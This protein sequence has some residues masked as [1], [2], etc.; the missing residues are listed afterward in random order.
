M[1]VVAAH[2]DDDVEAGVVDIA[3]LHAVDA[4]DAAE[5]VIVIAQRL[6]AVLERPRGEI[7]EVVRK[8]VLDGAGEDRLVARGGDLQIVGQA[9]GVVIIR[10]RH[11]ERTRLGGHQ[12]GEFLFAAAER[13]GNDHSYV[14][15]R[16][17]D[18]G[19]D[20]G[21][22]RDRFAGL[23]AKLGRR[24]RRR[25]RR[26]VHLG[27]HFDLASVQPLE[28]QV[29]RHHLGERGGMAQAVGI[30]RLHHRAGIGVDDDGGIGGLVALGRGRRVRCGMVMTTRAG[31]GVIGGRRG[32]QNRRQ[33]DRAP[34]RPALEKGSR[35][36]HRQLPNP[37]LDGANGRHCLVL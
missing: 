12:F 8:A 13:L 2:I 21:F 22:H 29:E 37:Y 14:I 18:D 11:A 20:R 10:M 7:G 31:A 32:E 26:D 24:H 34:T 25:M 1:A 17:G 33:T 30:G 4:G 19:A 27:G 36:Q 3:G 6:A 5:Q 35:T 15:G 28:Q 23:E 16:L 9:G